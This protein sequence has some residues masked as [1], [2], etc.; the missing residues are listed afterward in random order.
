MVKPDYLPAFTLD[1]TDYVV[2]EDEGGII[3]RIPDDVV[4]QIDA[5]IPRNQRLRLSLW[6][7][8]E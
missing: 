4:E 2:F 7:E 6:V 8:R 5:L 3:I 1:D